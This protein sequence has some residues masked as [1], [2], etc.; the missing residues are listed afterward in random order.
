MCCS[1]GWAGLAGLGGPPDN[2]CLVCLAIVAVMGC[3][4]PARGD[5]YRDSHS[6]SKK[7]ALSGVSK[8]VY[9]AVSFFSP[10]VI[11][12]WSMI[13]TPTSFRTFSKSLLGWRQELSG[14]IMLVMFRLWGWLDITIS[15]RS[16]PGWCWCGGPGYDGLSPGLG[17]VV[18]VID[19]LAAGAK[20]WQL[21]HTHNHLYSPVYSPQHS[22]GQQPRYD[23]LLLSTNHLH[24]PNFSHQTL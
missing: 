23:V 21:G 13:K 15:P 5:I 6:D 17:W 9:Y 12:F 22:A 16:S 24:L 8:K 2:F 1:K 18:M 10:N 3:W 14:N 4:G 19:M 7:D 20:S 11:C